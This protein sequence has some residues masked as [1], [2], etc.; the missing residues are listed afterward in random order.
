MRQK[1]NS[2][3]NGMKWN[4]RGNCFFSALLPFS[5][6]SLPLRT[7]MLQS[8]STPTHRTSINKCIEI[9]RVISNHWVIW[10]NLPPFGVSSTKVRWPRRVK[11]NST[12]FTATRFVSRQTHFLSRQTRFFSWQTHLSRQTRLLSR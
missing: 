6:P 1:I 8:K 5:P 9:S 12:S 3:T 11:A 4:V 10:S 7:T 2:L